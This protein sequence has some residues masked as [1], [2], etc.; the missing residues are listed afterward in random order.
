MVLD[1]A[2][3]AAR[4]PGRTLAPVLA[5]LALAVGCASKVLGQG[6]DVIRGRVTDRQGGAMAD[7]S[8]TILTEEAEALQSGQTDRNGRYVLVVREPRDVYVLSFRRVGFAT[9]S[10]TARRSGLGSV[11]DVEDVILVPR[12]DILQPVVTHSVVLVPSRGDH[13]A[14]GATQL[15]AASGADFVRDPSDLTS[16]I[17]QLPGVTSRGDSAFSVLG[18]DPGQ[19][20]TLVDGADFGGTS[21][22][23]DAIAQTKLIVNTFDPSQ[24]RFAGGQ[25][26]V[27]TRRGG[28]VFDGVARGQVLGPRLA[29]ADPQSPTGIPTVGALSGY[30]SGP[31]PDSNLTYMVAAEM[32]QGFVPTTS[33]LAPH[34]AFLS[35]IGLAQDTIAAT[36]TAAQGLGVPLTVEPTSRTTT[37]FRGSAFARGDL[38][39]S[40]TTAFTLELLENW[41]DAPRLATGALAFPSTASGFDAGTTRLLASGSTYLGRALDEF[42][43]AWGSTGS[44][45][46][47]ISTLPDAYVQAGTSLSDGQTGLATLRLGGSGSAASTMTD[48]T[49]NADHEVSWVTGDGR[50]QFKLTQELLFEWRASTDGSNVIGTYEY[51]T[52]ADLASNRPSS[53]QRAMSTSEERASS[54]SG[55]ASAGDTW[56]AIPG[57]LDLQ[58]GVRLD[59]TRFSARPPFNELVDSLFGV[60][61]D[62]VPADLGISPRLGFL[63]R[64]RGSR[65]SPLVPAGTTVL[66]ATSARGGLAPIDA[67]GIAM[68][69]DQSEID[70]AGGVGAFRGVVPLRE[71]GALVDETGVASAPRY[72]SCIGDATPIPDWPQ[73]DGSS[74]TTCR[75]GAPDAYADSQPRIRVSSPGF[76]PPVS[77]RGSL[78]VNGLRARGWLIAPQI[79]YA[80]GTHV[81]SDVDLNFRDTPAFTLPSEGGRPVFAQAGAIDPATGLIGPGSARAIAAMGPVTETMSDLQY[82]A[83]QL[84]ISVAPVKALP[85]GGRVFAV[86]SFMPQRDEQRGFDGPTG[87]D[88]RS[89]SW[90]RGGQP[91]N[92][93]IAGV[94]QGFGWLRVAARVSVFSGA[95]F[96]PMV[97]QD[98]N[99][100]GLANDRAFIPNPATLPNTQV[101]RD[102]QSLLQGASGNVRECLGS[103]L[104]TIAATNSCQTG[105][106]ARL[107]VAMDAAPTG[108]LGMGDRWRV[109]AQVLNA[110]SGVVRLLHLQNTALGRGQASAVI[111]QRLLYVIGFD[112][113]AHQ[114]QYRVNQQFG[115][116]I[117]GRALGALELQ[118]GAQV[119]LG[120][121]SSALP[122]RPRPPLAGDSRDSAARVHDDL[123]SRFIGPDPIQALLAVR[124][125]LGLTDD[126][127]LG[128][129]TVAQIYVTR[130]DSILAPIVA[131]AVAQ[132]DRLTADDLRARM[133]AVMAPLEELG[134][135]SRQRAVSFLTASQQL[136]LASLHP[137]N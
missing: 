109:T 95:A 55:G 42:H 44:R 90:V 93:F 91:T 84:T 5:C 56:N 105:W 63:W 94:A 134:R 66:G 22:P 15:N 81:P 19:N 135:S 31:S 8:V 43:A 116:P 86:Y 113:V 11:I 137:P 14:I 51:P 125:S 77:W 85:G 9:L 58:G 98:I 32:S 53:F 110:G 69:A 126:Q 20:R 107:D 17:T 88:P 73:G 30:V 70:V 96:T 119:S 35:A 67:G 37:N 123:V 121:R 39:V 62:R 114:H 111:D 7:V 27:T 25:A 128:I 52:I 131:F 122:P 2:A 136:K 92:Q 89:V 115:Q 4:G 72:L 79:A 40:G 12:L 75:G 65:R 57:L 29:W 124:D 74:P 118:V 6:S 47:P 64:V 102:L 24:G 106:F 68:P 83:A 21:V 71:I 49:V 13:P 36:G 48:Q 78:G 50:H 101:A 34:G 1:S 97:A 104:G 108:V 132:G 82:R 16:L 80:L 103:Q 59:A 33:L 99:G 76:R 117:N 3:R 41:N 100:D 45:I 38:R 112:S 127:T 28:P 130:R 18:A 54:V 26:T 87:G 120:I 129:R 23:R 133:Q 61:T 10:K 60:R 46:A